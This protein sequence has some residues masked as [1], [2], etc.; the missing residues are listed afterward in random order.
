MRAWMPVL[1]II[2]A[3]SFGCTSERLRLNTANQVSTLTD[4][5]HHIVLNNLA[6]FTCNPDAIPFQ[7]NFTS[8]TTQVADSGSA[9]VEYLTRVSVS[10]GLS[11]SAVDQWSMAPVT[12]EITLRLLRIA[13]R[14]GLGF[15]EDLYTEDLANRV[16]HR[17]KGQIAVAPDVAVQN[18]ILFTRGPGLAQLLDR[19]G[20]SGDTRLGFV[21]TDEA[22]VRWQKD[23]TDIISSNSDRIIQVGERLTPH[24]LSVTPLLVNGMPH[25]PPG[26]RKPR[27][28]VAT[29][30]ATELRRQVLALNDYL[31]EIGPGWLNS[32]QHK[33]EIPPCVCYIGHHKE[34][35]CNCFVWVE[36]EAHDAFEDFTLR[37]LRLISLVRQETDI[38]GSQGIMFSPI[39]TR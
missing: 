7:A 18:A 11:R 15:E 1:L 32:G 26:E 13:Y 16:A 34:C 10:L 31:L 37:T 27:V 36:P 38:V 20:W 24:T 6:A 28:L 3:T 17:L 21:A 8:G 30:Y 5:Q 14:R 22:V 9:V 2:I 39:Q 23:T 29:P 35:E 25:T 4:L 33:K 12:D 19:P